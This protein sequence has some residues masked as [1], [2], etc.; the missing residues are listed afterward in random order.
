MNRSDVGGTGGIGLQSLLGCASRQAFSGGRSS[1]YEHGCPLRRSVGFRPRETAVSPVAVSSIRCCSELFSSVTPR[2]RIRDE[3]TWAADRRALIRRP[4]SMSPT[5]RWTRVGENPRYG[6][7]GASPNMFTAPASPSRGCAVPGE[8]FTVP[9]R[10]N[11]LLIRPARTSRR[12]RG[13]GRSENLHRRLRCI[14]C[15]D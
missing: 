4:F 6:R 15:H 1:S 7:E 10:S 5:L 3:A 9:N 14:L 11:P 8:A 2:F 12:S 13:R